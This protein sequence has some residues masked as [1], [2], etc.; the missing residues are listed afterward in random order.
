MP[1]STSHLRLK[2][3][4]VTLLAFQLGPE[5]L[6]LRFHGIDRDHV[7]VSLAGRQRGQTVSTLQLAGCGGCAAHGPCDAAAP[8][9]RAR[10]GRLTRCQPSTL[11]REPYSAATSPR[12]PCKG[13][14]S[15]AH[16]QPTAVSVSA[17]R[18]W[19]PGG[20]RS[21]AGAGQWHGCSEAA[22]GQAVTMKSYARR[23]LPVLRPSRP[24]PVPSSVRSDK[25]RRPPAAAGSPRGLA[26]S[27]SIDRRWSCRH[28]PH[29]AAPFAT[30][31]AR[32]LQGSQLKI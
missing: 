24:A 1:P 12:A 6:L 4:Q 5:Q 21:A 2:R 31:V 16:R 13:A 22:V 17:A 27:S 19:A 9:R 18:P 23:Y 7:L 10:R 8:T 32:Q 30:S 20:G 14:F 15:A 28:M 25:A 29:A 3:H 26:R 11:C